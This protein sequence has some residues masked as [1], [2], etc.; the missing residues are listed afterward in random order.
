MTTTLQLKVIPGYSRYAVSPCGKIF[1][2]QRHTFVAQ[3]LS[4]IPQYYYCNVYND[5]GE[6]KLRR[7]HNLTARA[8]IENPEGK[9]YVDHIDRDKFNNHVDNLRWVTRSENVR[10]RDCTLYTEDGRCVIDAYKEDIVG[11]CKSDYHAI[12]KLMRKVGMTY[13][14]AL[15]KNYGVTK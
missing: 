4:G 8:Y 15:E 9:K 1:D 12:W 5:N 7:V 11:A 6:R 2:L 10:N 14:E 3:M 13:E